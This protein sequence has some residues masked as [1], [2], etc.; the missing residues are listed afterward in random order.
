VLLEESDRVYCNYPHVSEVWLFAGLSAAA[1]ATNSSSKS[2][3]PDRSIVRRSL[4]RF[5]G[6]ARY[7][8]ANIAH[9]AALLEAEHARLRGRPR[10]ALE[11]YA[12]VGQLARSPRACALKIPPPSDARACAPSTVPLDLLGAASDRELEFRSRCVPRRVV[13]SGES[14]YHLGRNPVSS[15][16]PRVRT[17]PV[18]AVLSFSCCRVDGVRRGQLG[19][20]H[21]LLRCLRA[22]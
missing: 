14:L 19:F 12:R 10:R 21:P 3:R 4:Q 6:F 13:G 2:Q 18:A 15:T 20:V 11:L 5:Q 1:V 22:G 7:G 8:P 16:S 9:A 17:S